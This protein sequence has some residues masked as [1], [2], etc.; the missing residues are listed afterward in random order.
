MDSHQG[1]IERYERAS[2]ADYFATMAQLRHSAWQ[3]LWPQSG[4]I[5]PSHDSYVALRT[6]RPEGGP[7]VELLRHG[8]AGDHWW[9]EIIIHYRDGSQCLAS[10]STSCKAA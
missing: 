9:S 8:G 7:R 1:V 3:M 4:E 2:V 6:H 10:R 5:V